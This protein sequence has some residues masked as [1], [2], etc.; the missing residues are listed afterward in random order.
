MPVLVFRKESPE[1]LISVELEVITGTNS[2]TH[3]QTVQ[4]EIAF[5][6]GRSATAGETTFGQGDEWNLTVGG[7]LTFTNNTP[8]I[9]LDSTDYAFKAG[10]NRDVLIPDVMD[11]VLTDDEAPSVLVIEPGGSTIVI[12]PSDLVVLGEGFKG[13]NEADAAIELFSQEFGLLTAANDAQSSADALS[14]DNFLA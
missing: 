12:E 11:I 6:D 4:L 14:S 9:A 10:D 2:L 1:A 13:E 7:N 8:D 5:D 3:F